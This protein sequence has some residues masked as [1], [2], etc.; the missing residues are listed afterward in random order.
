MHFKTKFFTGLIIVLVGL[1]VALAG[2]ISLI[3]NVYYEED[4]Q[5]NVITPEPP[6]LADSKTDPQL[7]KAEM[8]AA[9]KTKQNN[10][11]AKEIKLPVEEK[12]KQ[13]PKPGNKKLK[14]KAKKRWKKDW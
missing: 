10:K 13:K 4:M 9:A 12:E 2:I 11:K 6:T 7:L 14:T 1:F 3:D 5:V 8:K